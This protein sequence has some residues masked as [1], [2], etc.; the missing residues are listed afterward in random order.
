MGR[1]EPKSDEIAAL[2]QKARQGDCRAFNELVRRY[3]PRIYALA[4]HVT[5]SESDA[6]DIAQ[7]VFIRAYRALDSFEGRGEFFR[8]LYRIAL[9]L[10]FTLRR[11]RARRLGQ[12]LDDPRVEFGVAVD[13]AG[14]PR[15]AAALRQL[16]S[17]LVVALDRLSPPIR[18]SVILV[19][20]QGFSYQQAAEIL[21]TNDGTIAWRIHA[22][23]DK[24]R[25]AMKGAK[26]RPPPPPP[27]RPR[28]GTDEHETY[29]PSVPKRDDSDMFD[30]SSLSAWYN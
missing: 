6:D 26:L 15:K 16:Y 2:V 1:A 11:D 7:D 3:R 23:R 10:A 19:C 22:A 12:T 27:K 21:G 14:N 5:G 13:A 18:A 24:L 30:L 29:V 17:R 25:E 20:L 9:H 28:R 8:W 4:L